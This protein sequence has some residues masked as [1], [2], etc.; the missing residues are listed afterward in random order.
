MRD[1]AVASFS[2]IMAYE[3]SSLALT[4]A[5]TIADPKMRTDTEERIA[6]EWMKQDPAG[7]RAWIENSARPDAE[8]TRLLSTTP[9]L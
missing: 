9:G 2:A 5:T 8:K 7:A 3:N 1:E 6:L 4:W